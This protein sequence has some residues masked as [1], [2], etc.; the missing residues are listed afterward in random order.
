LTLNVHDIIELYDLYIMENSKAIITKI[1]NSHNGIVHIPAETDLV[2]LQYVSGR[3][4]VLYREALDYSPLFH[5]RKI[6][7]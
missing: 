5:S 4:T 7:E 3:E 6:N 2:Y 1:V